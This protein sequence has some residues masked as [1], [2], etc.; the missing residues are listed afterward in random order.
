MRSRKLTFR[1]A[2]LLF[3]ALAFVPACGKKPVPQL[4]SSTPST[5]ATKAPLTVDEQIAEARTHLKKAEEIDAKMGSVT[6][7]TKDGGEKE[8]KTFSI[9]PKA[10]SD[11]ITPSREEIETAKA[12][13]LLKE[14]QSG[15]SERA[16]AIRKAEAMKIAKNEIEKEETPEQKKAREEIEKNVKAEA[17]NAK[18]MREARA[19]AAIVCTNVAL[20]SVELVDL[21]FFDNHGYTPRVSVTVVNTHSFPI[22]IEKEGGGTIVRNLCPGGSITL[23][24][25]INGWDNL[26]EYYREEVRFIARGRFTDGALG[27]QFSPSFVI[28]V[29]DARY[30]G[31]VKTGSWL[32]Q[33]QK[34][35]NPY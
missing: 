9:K 19:Y 5:S 8:E 22:S 14:K 16:T 29:S 18:A 34:V 31:K 20:Q 17:K 1:F 30:N 6:V 4:P 21:T 2:I 24:R 25:K 35:T 28:S 13:L 15:L 10:T 23:V 26:D 12:E 27:L 11:K 33:L 7:P 3:V 32:I